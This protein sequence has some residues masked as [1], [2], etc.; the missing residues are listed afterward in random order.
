MSR[1]K[2][3]FVSSRIFYWALC[4]GLII[5]LA[6]CNTDKQ[7][8]A[9][10]DRDPEILAVIEKADWIQ[11]S[12]AFGFLLKNNSP[13]DRDG[14]KTTVSQ[15]KN[16]LIALMEKPGDHFAL[17]VLQTRLRDA[18]RFHILLQDQNTFEEFFSGAAQ[19]LYK[20]GQAARFGLNEMEWP[21]FAYL[22]SDGIYPFESFGFDRMSPWVARWQLA[23][24]RSLVATRGNSGAS[25]L[26]SPAMDLTQVESPALRLQHDIMI[27][28]GNRGDEFDPIL[29]AQE[30]FQVWVSTEDLSDDQWKRMAPRGS[31]WEQFWT[32]IPQEELSPLPVSHDFQAVYSPRISLERFKSPH[33]RVAL[34]LNMPSQRLE[35]LDP[36]VHGRLLGNHWPSWT[37][38]R[39]EIFGFG[40][41]A[42]A[43]PRRELWALQFERDQ[44]ANQEL[45]P[46]CQNKMESNGAEWEIAN[47]IP[48]ASSLFFALINSSRGSQRAKTNS[49]LISPSIILGDQSD[50]LLEIKERNQ[51]GDEAKMRI[52]ILDDSLG[53]ESPDELIVSE[54][55]RAQPLNVE[56]SF[57][58]A[59]NQFDLSEF[60]NRRIR[61]GFQFTQGWQPP[62]EATTWQIE[63]LSI[64]GSGRQIDHRLDHPRGLCE[65]GF[66]GR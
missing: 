27:N 61:L 11:Q 36:A 4:S 40:K 31:R 30:A 38:Y 9:V 44:M 14:I 20:Q 5:A 2:W 64:H 60:K 51:R 17:S 56:G 33:T 50:L 42:Y 10:P 45:S 62:R 47:P 19:I 48:N 57:S 18:A 55:K 59:A 23:F 6:G 41:L 28:Q 25:M 54:L 43:V 22:F 7:S 3:A 12:I 15:I 58:N 16:A 65:V 29:I 35:S 1:L 53:S 26:V 34:I 24:G 8:K 46:F 49:W 39:F 13:R 63:R 52:F 21:L 32:R 37:V 66:A